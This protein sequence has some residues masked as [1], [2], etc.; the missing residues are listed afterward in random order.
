MP[1]LH[2]H[3]HVATPT[4]SSATY[5]ISAS[6]PVRSMRQGYVFVSIYNMC[7]YVQMYMCV[8]KQHSCLRLTAQK[9]P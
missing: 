6:L 7:I 9:S 3:L 8:I 5:Y 1:L 2:V 4:Q